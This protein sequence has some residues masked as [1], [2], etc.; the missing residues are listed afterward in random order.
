[1]ASLAHKRDADGAAEEKSPDSKRA[2]TVSALLET[3]AEAAAGWAVR[4]VPNELQAAP[5]APYPAKVGMLTPA[6]DWG[7][8]FPFNRALRPMCVHHSLPT[9]PNPRRVLPNQI[10]RTRSVSRARRTRASS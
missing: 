10:P 6:N 8:L 3:T 9:P 1:M 4:H 2:K 7:H 5:D